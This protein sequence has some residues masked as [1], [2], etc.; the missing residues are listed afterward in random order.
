M[1]GPGN[2]DGL[3]VTLGTLDLA[4]VSS[5]CEGLPG[6][7]QHLFRLAGNTGLSWARATH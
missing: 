6:L 5:F 1:P 4:L 2:S 7:V 3:A